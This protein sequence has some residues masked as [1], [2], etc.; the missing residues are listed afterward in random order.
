MIQQVR[1]WVGCACNAEQISFFYH[2]S[3]AMRDTREESYHVSFASSLACL[4]MFD[5]KQ[6]QQ[7]AA[8]GILFVFV[9]IKNTFK[10]QSILQT[11][12]VRSSNTVATIRMQNA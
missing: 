2:I 3:L 8:S 11:V 5:K 9:I 7:L 1:T 10:R 12:I 6:G 4:F